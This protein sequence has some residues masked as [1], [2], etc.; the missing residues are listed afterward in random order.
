MRKSRI[1]EISLLLSKTKHKRLSLKSQRK[2]RCQIPCQ[3]YT[4]A[5]S[6]TRSRSKVGT[7]R[8][9]MPDKQANFLLIYGTRDESQSVHAIHHLWR[10]HAS[11]N[12]G[13]PVVARPGIY[14]IQRAACCRQ[15]TQG[16]VES[17][18]LRYQDCK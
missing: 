11:Q 13:Y 18:C 3:P 8:S 15:S 5:T 10:D 17:G 7:F 12:E 4:C 1:L 6:T 9:E 16:A 2:R 14:R